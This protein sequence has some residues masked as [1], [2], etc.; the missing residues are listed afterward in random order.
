MDGD[1]REA[2]IERACQGGYGVL[3]VD[4]VAVNREL[5]IELFESFD[6]VTVHSAACGAEG[7]RLA[8]AHAPELVLLDIFLAGMDGVEVARR[9]RAASAAA[10]GPCIVA[11]TAAEGFHRLGRDDEAAATPLFDAYVPKP[12]DLD[13]LLAAVGRHLL[14]LGDPATQD[15][16]ARNGG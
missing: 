6:G 5:L 1:L 3:V 16:S 4:D 9:L 10:A 13:E 12:V 8:A 2:A 15:R 11:I 7:L 14:R